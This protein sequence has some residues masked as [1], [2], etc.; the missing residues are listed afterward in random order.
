MG[1]YNAGQW[2]IRETILEIFYTPWGSALSVLIG[3]LIGHRLVVGR[4]RVAR[5]NSAADKFRSALHPAVVYMRSEEGKKVSMP[6]EW[7]RQHDIAAL[8]FR[9]YLS[10]RKRRAFDRDWQK[11]KTQESRK[12]PYPCQAGESPPYE[13]PA[14]VL[15]LVETFLKHAASK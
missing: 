15:K 6:S 14:L 11:Y 9:D 12:E 3:Y 8:E 2:F 10:K 1:G 7:I 5:F 4:D 13:D